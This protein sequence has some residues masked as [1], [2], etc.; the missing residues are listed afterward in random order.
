MSTENPILDAL[1]V[2][3]IV[4]RKDKPGQ[5]GRTE[6]RVPVVEKGGTP[7]AIPITGAG[8]TLDPSLIPGSSDSAIVTTMTAAETINA[9]QM[10]SVHS[11]G[12]AYLADV[13]DL[14]DTSQTIGMAITSATTGNPIT[15]QQVGFML[16]AG[17]NWITPGQTLYLGTTGTITT[18]VPSSPGSAFELPVGTVISNT[19]VE[20]QL[21][22]PIVLA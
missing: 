18:I 4:D 19:K 6:W 2:S 15:V 12:L 20:L 10:V 8:G 16:N 9:Y 11:D 7:G 22:L 17:W 5:V 14:A 3:V 21:G 13:T 1:D